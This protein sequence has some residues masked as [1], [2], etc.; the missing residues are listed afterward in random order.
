MEHVAARDLATA[1]DA[2]HTDPTATVLA[3]GTDLMVEVNFGHRRPGTVVSIRRVDAELADRSPGWIGAGVPYRRLE[4]DHH[5]ALAQLSRTVGSPQIRNAGTV[6]GNLGTASPAGDALP[7]LAAA[8]ATVVLASKERGRRRLAWDEFL[9]GPKRNAR[10]PDEL[11]LGVELPDG[12]PERQ[13]FAKIGTRNAMVI[14]MV[15]CVVTRADDGTTRIAVGSA[16]P[17]VLRV[18]RAEEVASAG[19]LTSADLDEVQRLVSEDVRPI[20]DHRATAAY[21]RQAAGVLARRLLERV[22]A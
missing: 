17:T 20:D 11:I 6:G 14:A 12:L 7:F 9:L 2:L 13:A 5:A 19:R 22:T 15:S 16:G 1:L 8:D 3:G 21:R 4:R 18:P 10:A